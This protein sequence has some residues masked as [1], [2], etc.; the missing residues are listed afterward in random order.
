MAVWVVQ[1][2]L[3]TQEDLLDC[4]GGPPVLLLVQ[5]GEAHSYRW[6]NIRM[7]QWRNKL[8]L[9]WSGRKVILENNLPLVQPTLPGC[10]LLAR[11]P[12]LPQHEIHGFMAW[13]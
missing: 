2:I 11:D 9:G 12:I 6:V 3:D 8:D 4:D 7:K 5:D 1:Q 10:A 13:Q